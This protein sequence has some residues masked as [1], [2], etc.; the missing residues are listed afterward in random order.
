MRYLKCI[1]IVFLINN[2]YSQVLNVPEITQEQNQWCWAGVSKCILDYYSYPVEQCEIAEYARQVITWHNFG[3]TDCCANP[4]LGCNYWNYNWGYPGSIQDILVHFGDI[5]N[6]GDW[7]LTKPEI[8]SEISAGRPFVIR[9]GWYSGGGHFVVGHGIVGDNVYY[10]DPWFGEGLHVATYEWV[11]DDGNHQ[12]TSTNVLTATANFVPVNNI[13]DVPTVVTAGTPLTLTGTVLPSNATNQTIVW[14]I[15][16][17]GTTGATITGN[18]LNTFTSGIATVK[19]T[20]T[21]GLAQET[22]Y[23]QD[24]SITVNPKIYTITFMPNGGTGSMNPQ[25]F[26]YNEPQNLTPNNFTKTGY[27]FIGW[28]TQANGNGETYEDEQ[29][30]MIDG[31]KTLFAQWEL[32]EGIDEH[33]EI[34][35]F[36]RIVPNPANEYIDLQI[37]NVNVQIN[38]IE[39]YNVYGQLVK[40]VPYSGEIKNNII[41]QRISIADLSTG[42]Y[43]IKAEN[44]RAKLI[45]Q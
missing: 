36:L 31:N 16:N 34:N 33:K 25:E 45:I 22:D 15:V 10:M 41:T 21:N 23:T 37:S 2:A 4:N 43:L 6:Y 13:T 19:A 42:I 18:T 40:F 44:G 14:S 9:W 7:Y 1:I 12:W 8:T 38:N 39:F 35:S 17:A 11:Y 26:T 5:Q 3:S 32:I 30:I 27:K 29:N 20:I 24:F 28:N